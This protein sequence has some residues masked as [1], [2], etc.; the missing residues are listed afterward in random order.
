MNCDAVLQAM[1]NDNK[2][3]P[4]VVEVIARAASTATSSDAHSAGYCALGMELEED[5]ND[6]NDEDDDNNNEEMDTSSNSSDVPIGATSNGGS[7]CVSS[8][9]KSAV[10]GGSSSSG[11]TLGDVRVP[12]QQVYQFYKVSSVKYVMFQ[13]AVAKSLVIPCEVSCL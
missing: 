2:L 4:L 8:S 7:S 9:F 1:L 6:N 10:G 13:C 5:D 12:E 11:S 3:P